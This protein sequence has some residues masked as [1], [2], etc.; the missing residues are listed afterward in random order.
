MNRSTLSICVSCLALI[1]SLQAQKQSAPATASTAATLSNSEVP[2]LKT[3]AE[4]GDIAAQMELARAYESG[5]GVSQNDELAAQWCRRAAEQGNPDAQNHLGTIYRMGIGVEKSKE[6]AVIWYRKAARQKYPT[7][8]FNLGTAYYNGDGVRINDVLAD[9]WFL[10]AQTN[11][12]QS[13]NDAVARMT[14]DLSPQDVT[15]SYVRV[16]VMLRKGDEIPRNDSEAAEWYRKAADRGNALASV[17]LA[18]QLVAGLGVR[19]D[20]TEARSRCEDAAKARFGPGAYCLGLMNKDGLGGPKNLQ[21]AAKWF[22]RA[23]EIRDDRAMVDLGE[24]YWKGDGVKQNKET[25]YMWLWIAANSGIQGGSRDE[26]QL[27]QEMDSNSI[28]K[29]R[30]KAMEWTK[31]HPVLVL[32]RPLG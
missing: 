23:A 21:E 3:R 7:A 16:A 20:Y 12:S 30:H 18:Q 32:R 25:A 15:E 26:Q 27:R 11:G 5:K 14:T 10:L 28:E 17:E 2:Q 9:A 4:A 6:E 22:A 1:V 8:M 24:M 31:K 13:A 29:A 19:Q